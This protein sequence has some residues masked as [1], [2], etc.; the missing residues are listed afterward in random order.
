LPAQIEEQDKILKARRSN[1][2]LTTDKIVAALPELHIPEIH[3]ACEGV[4]RL[5]RHSH[6][7][8]SSHTARARAC[9]CT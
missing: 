4:S 1:N 8:T 7:A 9:A 3:E 5:F 6:A 2:L